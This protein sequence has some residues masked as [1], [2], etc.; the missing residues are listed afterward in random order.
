MELKDGNNEKGRKSKGKRWLP[1][2]TFIFIQPVVFL[3][4]L[5]CKKIEIHGYRHVGMYLQYANLHKI[6]FLNGKVVLNPLIP[7]AGNKL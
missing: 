6:Q 2:L 3:Y 1:F 5:T 4:A 7:S